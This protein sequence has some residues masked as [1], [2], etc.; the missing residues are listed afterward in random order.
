MCSVVEKSFDFRLKI[1]IGFAVNLHIVDCLDFYFFSAYFYLN[2]R[3][4]GACFESAAFCCG[5]R[6][7]VIFRSDA[8]S[9]RNFNFIAGR[10]AYF[11]SV[12]LVCVLA[13]VPLIRQRVSVGRTCFN[14]DFRRFIAVNQVEFFGLRRYRGRRCACFA[15]ES[16]EIGVFEYDCCRLVAVFFALA[17][18][19]C[20]PV[21]ELSVFVFKRVC[22]KYRFGF[23]DT[24]RCGFVLAV[25]RMERDSYRHIRKKRSFF[26]HYPDFIKVELSEF[27]F[28]RKF[29][30]SRH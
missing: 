9:C 21:E 29:F 6:A 5:Y 10:A 3:A 8:L 22:V 27:G 4:V 14:F 20:R 15:P 18:R 30:Y 12:G 7:V 26:S 28:V 13:G 11:G 17:R 1:G 23:V 19:F 16:V 25:F 24:L 2:Y